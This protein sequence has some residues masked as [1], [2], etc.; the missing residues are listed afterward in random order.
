MENSKPSSSAVSRRYSIPSLRSWVYDTVIVNMTKRWYREVLTKLPVN[1]RILD[2]G[3]GTG[4]SLLENR[5]LIV[6]KHL[7]VTGVDYDEHYVIAAIENVKR[8]GLEQ[9]VA[10]VHAS[11]HDYSP[12]P[13]SSSSGDD[14]KENQRPFD[15]IYFSGSFMIIPDKA[16]ALKRCVRMLKPTTT[17]SSSGSG[18]VYFTQTFEHEGIVGRYVTPW[19]KAAL[20]TLLTIDFGTVTFEKDFLAVL[21][22]ANVEVEQR[23]S[24]GKAMFREQVLIVA[25]VPVS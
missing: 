6:S 4:T 7:H 21:Q 17:A 25:M 5:D 24:L 13:S 20:K 8:F 22:A 15:A 3:I 11:I 12:S 14:E 10:L 2:V 23:I 9:Q 16:E 19:V 1:A 18:R